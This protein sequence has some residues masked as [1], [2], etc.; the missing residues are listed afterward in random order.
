MHIIDTQEMILV[1]TRFFGNEL[2]L[3]KLLLQ[4]STYPWLKCYASWLMSLC[5][6]K[7]EWFIRS[8]PWHLMACSI[9][10]EQFCAN[11]THTIH[12]SKITR[13]RIIK[14]AIEFVH[15]QCTCAYTKNNKNMTWRKFSARQCQYQNVSHPNGIN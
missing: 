11:T 1:M 15:A 10:N 13:Y 4:K 8:K 6:I 9:Q 3:S 2:C 12:L 7:Y 14:T 5:P